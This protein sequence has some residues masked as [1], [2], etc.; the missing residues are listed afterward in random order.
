MIDWY[1]EIN[2]NASDFYKSDKYISK[3]IDTATPF[4]NHFCK[5][6]GEIDNWNIEEAEDRFSE[7]ISELPVM[8]SHIYNE[9]FIIKYNK[10]VYIKLT[11]TVKQI[12]RESKLNKILA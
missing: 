1:V 5:R 3:V 10:W 4:M 8:S 6:L 7:L 2:K 11:D 12:Y 9:E